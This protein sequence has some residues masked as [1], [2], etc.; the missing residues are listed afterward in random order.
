MYFGG[1]YYF[2][3]G[4]GTFRGRRLISSLNLLFV[5]SSFLFH[6]FIDFF[7]YGGIH[8]RL[9]VLSSMYVAIDDVD[10]RGWRFDFVVLTPTNNNINGE[11]FWPGDL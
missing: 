6:L 8:F 5:G 1:F 7:L 4:G 11:L 2:L 9:S 10:V 3:F